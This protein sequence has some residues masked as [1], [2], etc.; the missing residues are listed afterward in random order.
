MLDHSKASWS[1]DTLDYFPGGKVAATWI[2][3]YNPPSAEVKDEWNTSSSPTR[4]HGVHTDK[5]E[6]DS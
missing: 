3:P 2:W 1:I 4:L 6:L 5:L